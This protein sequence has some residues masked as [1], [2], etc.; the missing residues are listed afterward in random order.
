MRRKSLAIEPAWNRRQESGQQVV[1]PGDTMGCEQGSRVGPG[2]VSGRRL[3]GSQ[4]FPF[5]VPRE[6]WGERSSNRPFIICNSG[7]ASIAILV[8]CLIF[9]AEQN[10]KKL[11]NSLWLKK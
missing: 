11:E 3:R 7:P 5:L 4:L 2:R 9:T 6:G 8:L 10:I 1:C